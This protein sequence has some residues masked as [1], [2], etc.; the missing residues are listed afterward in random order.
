VLVNILAPIIIRLFGQ[1]L[2][3][4]VGEG[5]TLLLSGILLDQEPDVLHAADAAGFNQV[6]RLTD[7]DWVGLALT[8]QAA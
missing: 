7:G 6:E 2:A 1:G 3:E 4:L 8:K 5:G